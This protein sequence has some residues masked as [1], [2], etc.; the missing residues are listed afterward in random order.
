MTVRNE[1]IPLIET[2]YNVRHR[3]VYQQVRLR[4]HL[5]ALSDSHGAPS[6]NIFYGFTQLSHQTIII[7][8]SVYLVC[9]YS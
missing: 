1:G 4:P 2:V 9:F 7:I 3:K 6:Q 8:Y 5:L